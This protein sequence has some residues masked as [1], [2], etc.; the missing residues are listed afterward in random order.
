[1]NLT[2]LNR[3]A[4]LWD[5]NNDNLNISNHSSNSY[6]A[7]TSTNNIPTNTTVH[8]KKKYFYLSVPFI[9]NTVNNG[10]KH[11]FKYHNLPVRLSHRSKT[12]N[13][14]INKNRTSRNRQCKKENCKIKNNQ[15]CLQ[16][17]VVYKITCNRCTK[18]YVGS[19]YRHLHVR[20]H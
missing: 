10:L 19:T 11:L 17:N 12:H 1:M 20:F 3:N 14:A 9:N 2:K 6:V 4:Y 5:N 8:S 13:N 7:T 15:L 18:N 16:K